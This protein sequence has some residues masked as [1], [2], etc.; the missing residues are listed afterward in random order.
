MII[1]ASAA[2]IDD[3]CVRDVWLEI[4]NGII[5]SLKPGFHPSPD[6]KTEHTIIPGFVD[7]HCHGGG[8]FYFSANSDDEI[9]AAINT[10][11]KNGTTSL[12]A[13]LVS[14]NFDDLRTQIHR[15]VPFF[16]T[17]EIVGIHLEG[18]YLSH[19]RCGA[20][21]PTLLLSPSIDQLQEL[22]EV[23]EGSIKMATIAPEL[24][25]APECFKY[26]SS[27]GI[28]G[29]IGHTNG[30]YDDASLATDN[31]ARVV[32]HFLNGMSKEVSNGSLGNFVL[33]DSRLAVELIVDG[34]HLDFE[35]I[36]ELH[37]LL[38]DRIILVSDAMSAAGMS[39]G[40]YS[41]GSLPVRVHD[42]VARLASNNA[43][44]GSTLTLSDAFLNAIQLCG[45]SVQQAVNATSAHPARIMGL[46][47][48]GSIAVGKKADLLS[49]NSVSHALQV[50]DTSH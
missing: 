13:S 21:D 29:A 27:L 44:A 46:K 11:K 45:F 32:S 49:Y 23:G 43:L 3:S 22:I 36:T 12:V 50:I 28:I 14:A 15:L 35:K 19:D 18:P 24:V 30:N 31:G 17:G 1:Q 10:H 4:S 37:S 20:H 33:R 47:D 42:G 8:G 25:G 6:I 38:G 39:D 5:S 34:H 16:K 26:L 40:D 2:I 9:R 48:R 7:I 41:I